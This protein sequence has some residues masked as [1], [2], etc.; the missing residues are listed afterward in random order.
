VGVGGFLS[1]HAVVAVFA[2]AMFEGDLSMVMAGVVAH[3]GYAS[4][5][6]AIQAACL[7]AF[8]GDLGWYTLGRAGAGHLRET[9]LYR[10]AAPLI[11]RLATRLGEV[12]IV[13]ARFVYGTR[14]A[15]MIFWGV[16]GLPLVR[17][18]AFDLL[19]CTL[20]ALA[21]GLLGYGLSE[22]ALVI[23]GRVRRVERW[24]AAAALLGA[25]ILVTVRAVG[26]RAARAR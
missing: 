26:R 18:A 7:G 6:V 10:R 8:A 24:L 17:F 2:G 9:V 19:G 4:L 25:T 22:S 23:F 15:S 13:L 12:E 11:E 1:R 5:P 3:L 20:A 21:L 16:R 14:I